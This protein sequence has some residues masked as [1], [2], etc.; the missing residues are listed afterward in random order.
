MNSFLGNMNFSGSSTCFTNRIF[1]N[2]TDKREVS[3]IE[4]GP[5]FSRPNVESFYT[6]LGVQGKQVKNTEPDNLKNFCPILILYIYIIL[7]RKWN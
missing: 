2:R 6:R 3:L 7:K 1:S 4:M 5:E